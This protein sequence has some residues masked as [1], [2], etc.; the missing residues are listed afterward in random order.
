MSTTEVWERLAH[1]AFALALLFGLALF[2][3]HTIDSP[4][5]SAGPPTIAAPPPHA[6]ALDAA[7]ADQARSDARN[8]S[9]SDTAETGLPLH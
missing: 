2:A 5:A 6:V 1:I 4:P 9:C 7:L 8:A 3:G